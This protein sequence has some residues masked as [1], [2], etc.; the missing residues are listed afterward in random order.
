M[1]KI[2]L[3][4]KSLM[5]LIMRYTHKESSQHDISMQHAA[6]IKYLIKNNDKDVHPKELEENFMMRK[7]TC[8]RMLSLMEYNGLIERKDDIID[9]RKKIIS[10]TPKALNIYNQIQSKFENIEDMMAQNIDKKDLE[11]FFKVLDQIK[12][13]ITEEKES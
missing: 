12:L 9:S 8:S 5:N 6:I 4:L 7:S 2:S 1:R 3:E 13:N 11:V 10:L